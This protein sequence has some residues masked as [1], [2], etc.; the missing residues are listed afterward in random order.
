[1][2]MQALACAD[3]F[4]IP[5]TMRK[6]LIILV[7]L[8]AIGIL[9][10][11]GLWLWLIKPD[12][13]RLS[14]AD[15]SG[16]NPTISAP[17]IQ[18][19]PTMNVA[20]AVGWAKDAMPVAGG[21]LHVNAF[22]RNLDHPRWMY[23]L[24]NGDILLAETNAPPRPSGGIQGWVMGRTMKKAGAGGASPNRII[25]L[26]DADL[27]GTAEFRTTFMS[28]LNSPFGMA[29]M[30]KYLYIG[31][32][33]A[34]VRVPYTS[35]QTH[36]N[37]KPETIVKLQPGG[38]WA[39]N[40]VAAP[41]G[42]SLFVGVGS[43]SNIADGGIAAEKNRAVVLQIDP[44][45][46]TSRIYAAGLRNPTGLAFEPHSGRLWVTVN[47]R[48]M[49]GSDLAPDYLT[50]VELG[51]H[52]GWP[53]YYWGKHRDMRV[54]PAN[55]TVEGQSKLPDYALGPHTASLGLTF[56]DRAKLGDSFA[57]GAFVGQ[58][59]SWNRVPAAGY[60]VVFVPFDTKGMPLRGSKPVDV[61]TGFLSASGEAQGRPVGVITDQTGA[62]LVAD[63][64]GN[65]IWRVSL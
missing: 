6:Y 64:V 43:A 1:M 44:V 15:V 33:D 63:D 46:K 48:D 28:G 10:A 27:D 40:V 18:T 59:G 31:N 45:E 8:T 20:N 24:S 54:I 5:I 2:D 55:P 11:G 29:V 47:E 37:A 34:L 3:I 17:R 50:H 9:F 57:N 7:G 58:H 60:K 38:H 56:A 13:A 23:Q 51:D 16:T 32:T 12:E 4:I 26:R 22:A 49:L 19:I 35:G 41:D 61:L 42:R 65:A 53:W 30:G 36:I 14:V 21:G 52:F 25:L 39:R 62:L